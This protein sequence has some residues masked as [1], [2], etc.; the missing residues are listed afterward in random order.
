MDDIKI[1]DYWQVDSV[2]KIL[3][4]NGIVLKVPSEDFHRA[5]GCIVSASFEDVQRDF[6]I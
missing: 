1:V 2:F 4:S 3:Y 6:A 5:F